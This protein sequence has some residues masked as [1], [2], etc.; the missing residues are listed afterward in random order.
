MQIAERYSLGEKLGSGGMGEV[1]RGTDTQT[2]RAVAIKH[3]KPEIATEEGIER[4]IREAEILRG[5][6][7]PNIVSLLDAVRLDA[8]HYLVM[9]LVAGG[10]L[11]D[12]LLRHTQIPIQQILEI[13]LEV[14]DALA[15]AHHLNI[16][17]R[18]I[19]PENILLAED[20]TPRLTDF[21]VAHIAE[22]RIT[23]SGIVLG[24]FAY[25]CPEV[26][27]GGEVTPRADI[28]ALGVTLFEMLAHRIPFDGDNLQATI[29]AIL[30]QP[31]PDLEQLRSDAPLALIDLIYR[32][33]AKNPT[34]RISSVRLV[35][36][37]LEAIV[38]GR[39]PGPAIIDQEPTDIIRSRF[40][41]TPVTDRY[42][43]NLPVQPTPFVGRQAELQELKN[44][45]AEPDICLITI[46]AVGGMGKTRLALEAAA[47]EVNNF[48]NGVFFVELKSLSTADNIPT[49]IASA[50]VYQFQE[51]NRSRHEQIL[52]F[53][54]NKRMLLILDNYEHLLE[55]ASFVS[56]ILQAAPNVK[57][58][59]TSRERLNLKEETLFRIGG[60]DFPDGKA[61]EAE[62]EYPAVK[63]FMQ[64]A[65]R[66]Q[67]GFEF[68]PDE[69]R[70]L[71]QICRLVQGMPLGLLLA[72]AWVDTLSLREITN[73]MQQSLDFLET[74]LQNVPDRQRSIRVV[75]DYTW[76]LLN[77]VERDV[78]MKL[79]VFRGG[80]T[81]QAAQEITDVSLRSLQTMVNRSL[82]RRD[83]DSG[84]YEVHELLR[85]YAEERLSISGEVDQTCDAHMQYYANALQQREA[86]LKGHRQLA[87]LDEIESDFENVRA[88]W[89]WAITHEDYAAI[90]S[91]LES[92]N[93]FCTMRSRFQER[94]DLLGA[95]REAL[96]PE[97][98]AEV[99]PVWNRVLLNSPSNEETSVI[100]EQC[101]KI[102]QHT[103]DKPVIAKCLLRQ[104]DATAFQEHDFSAAV[105]FLEESLALYR[106]LNDHFYVALLLSQLGRCHW[107]IGHHDEALSY[108]QQG[109]ELG[110]RIGDRVGTAS[111]LLLVGAIAQGAGNYIEAEACYQEARTIS[112]EVGD[113]RNTAFCDT[114]LAQNAFLRGDFEEARNLVVDALEIATDIQALGT[115]GY[116]LTL[117]G[118]LASMEEDY[119]QGKQLGEQSLEL[120]DIPVIKAVG[121]FGLTIANCGL[122][123]YA[124]VKQHI[125]SMLPLMSPG[126]SYLLVTLCLPIAAIILEQEGMK[127]RAVEVLSLAFSH[128]SSATGWMRKWPLLARLQENLKDSLGAQKY[129]DSWARGEAL[130]LEE[131]VTTLLPDFVLFLKDSSDDFSPPEPISEH[132]RQILDVH[133][134]R[135][136]QSLPE[137]LSQREIEILLLLYEG[138]TNTQIADQLFI[139]RGTVKQHVNR[140]LRKLDANNRSH[141][142]ARARELGLL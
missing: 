136:N 31:I 90:D 18:D 1:F 80:M 83:A 130:D 120:I 135:A 129:E 7:H 118:G 97:P 69:S 122:A 79:S 138:L 125:Q 49:A 2:G 114:T 50:L 9:E 47:A 33:L 133:I 8:R 67:P 58:V 139:A 92:L 20:G 91:M 65:T 78:F 71:T 54:S 70:F 30:T 104:G 35:G 128:P 123:D 48:S 121:Y 86:D 103:D 61:A 45:I 27:N 106:D 19:K 75:F 87:A 132:Q 15:R 66:V 34:E 59:V 93:L 64:G 112:Q 76:E 57:V 98:D 56:D 46:L 13:A 113:L 51:D 127:E 142:V 38:Q 96:V 26:L 88:A 53:L 62:L 124:R 85:Q 40:A 84:R 6:D 4:F 12:Y 73:E 137:P 29:T 81:R 37:E 77:D 141:S 119:A 82:L 105:P 111:S 110:R 140:I 107:Y 22:S 101:L 95:A 17:H 43:H 23:D 115:R 24:T 10:S 63:L 72:A 89:Y 32:M 116:A 68:D 25:V 21:G 94:A 108:Y 28:W 134:S 100:V 36:T 109:L 117:L 14:A 74:D 44:L 39:T 102:A 99:H 52:Q 41:P 5:L 60:V 16:I 55:G 42:Q 131:A 3:L 126:R 11:R